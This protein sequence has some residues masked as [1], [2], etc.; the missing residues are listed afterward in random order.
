MSENFWAFYPVLWQLDTG[1]SA[2]AGGYRVKQIVKA[3]TCTNWLW[4]SRAEPS[5]HVRETYLCICFY[6]ANKN[7]P[8]SQ[9]QLPPCLIYVL[10]FT[11][12]CFIGE[13]GRWP[14]VWVCKSVC[15]RER[16]DRKQVYMINVSWFKSYRWSILGLE[17]LYWCANSILS[18]V[19]I[20]I[21]KQD[22]N[23]LHHAVATAFILRLGDLFLFYFVSLCASAALWAH[24]R[25]AKISL[26]WT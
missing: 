24:C 25:Y 18:D 26:I 13:A 14:G 17:I 2:G 10:K 8:L 16:K 20:K 15:A 5:V 7:P 19:K 6:E 1:L 9:A 12:H 23:F 3:E 11:P 4:E 22:L 21:R